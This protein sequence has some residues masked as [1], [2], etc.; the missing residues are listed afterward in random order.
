MEEGIFVAKTID[1]RPKGQITHLK[2]SNS[3]MLLVIGGRHL[4]HIPLHNIG[5][6]IGLRAALVAVIVA[7]CCGGEWSGAWVGVLACLGYWVVVFILGTLLETQIQSDGTIVYS[8]ELIR[9]L[10]GTLLETQIQSDG[11]IVYSKELIR[12]LTGEKD[13][14]ITDIELMQ[15]YEEGDKQ[16]WAV[17]VCTPGRLYPLTGTLPQKTDRSV[18]QP[19]VG[20]IWNSSLIEESSAVLQP[21]FSFKE[22][23]RYHCCDPSQRNLPSS[24]VIHP[25][26]QSSAGEFKFCWISSQGYTL[27]AINL[28]TDDAFNMITEEAPIPHRLVN[29]RYDYPLDI[30]LTDYHLVIIFGDRFEA[31]SILN[32]KCTFN[33]VIAIVDTEDSMWELGVVD[34]WVAQSESCQLRGMC[35]DNVTELIW[36]YT[37]SNIIRYR[38]NEEG[39]SV[40]RIHLERGEY[41]KALSITDHLKDREPY[42]LVIKKQAEKFI[43]EKKFIAAAELLAQSTDPFEI[44]VLNFLSTQE[45]RRDGLKRFLELQLSKMTSS[46]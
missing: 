2:A 11:T 22:M 33:D 41:D 13:M 31:I 30:A 37:D 28:H 16:R 29:G 36:V 42:Q 6:Q 25:K 38:P 9:N 23:P 8:K 20:A 40:W 3:E 7:L 39:K 15:C 35:R 43:A 26:N 17:F 44:S 19:V 32:Q 10:T 24:F 34:V 12:N 27:G 14:P 21:L 1:Y 46:E 5:T 45:N 4:I 18:V